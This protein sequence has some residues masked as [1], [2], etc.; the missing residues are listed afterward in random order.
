MMF[1]FKPDYSLWKREVERFEI[2]P[3]S[4][5]VGH[6]CGG[7]FWVRYLS[8]HPELKVGKVVLVAPWLDPNN[9]RKTTFFDFEID[10]TVVARTKGLTIFNADN[11][12]P[13]ILTSVQTLRGALKGHKYR[14]FHNYG[15]F[16]RN[17]MKTD[18]FPELLD[19]ILG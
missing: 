13:G 12:H 10:P 15:H 1:A 7:G 6:S 8:E 9:I 17:D 16:C 14:E 19:E 4:I 3:E 5:L 11:D 18:H 2:G